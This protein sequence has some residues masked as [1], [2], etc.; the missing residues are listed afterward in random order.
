MHKFTMSDPLGVVNIKV[1][2]TPLKRLILVTDFEPL[3][4]RALMDALSLRYEFVQMKKDGRGG[5]RIEFE[6]TPKEKPHL[7]DDILEMFDRTVSR[8]N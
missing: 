3:E 6:F 8:A 5:A 2:I 1:T 4:Q 7:V